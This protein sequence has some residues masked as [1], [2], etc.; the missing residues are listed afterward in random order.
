M[1][2]VWLPWHLGWAYFT[3][4]TFIAASIAILFGVLARLAAALSAI[5]MALFLLLV[6]VPILAAGPTNAFQ[7]GEVST[8]LA[9][10]AAGWVVAE[11]YRGTR[12]LASSGGAIQR[13]RGTSP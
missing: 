4:V 2:P 3:G 7:Q 9:L 6:W 13:E 1:V 12:W 10:T 8:T 11:S 5:Q